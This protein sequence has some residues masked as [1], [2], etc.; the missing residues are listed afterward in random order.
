M[1]DADHSLVRDC[2]NKERAR[3]KCGRF[4]P[5]VAGAY[6]LMQQCLNEYIMSKEYRGIRWLAFLLAICMITFLR[7]FPTDTW[8]FLERYCAYSL[9][10]LCAGRWTLHISA[11]NGFLAHYDDCALASVACRTLH[12][13][14]R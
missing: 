12:D 5:W 1:D 14:R 13:G 10:V 6:G 11:Y 2:M 9:R 8:S 3:K 4:P 7:G